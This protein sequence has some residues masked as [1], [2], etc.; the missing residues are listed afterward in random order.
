MWPELEK[1]V[2]IRSIDTIWIEHLEAMASVRHVFARLDSVQI[3]EQGKLSTESEKPRTSSGRSATNPLSSF[4][5]YLR[6]RRRGAL[7]VGTMALMILG[8]PEEFL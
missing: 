6:H 1:A 5:F 8:V 3:L 2:L 7:L 4:T